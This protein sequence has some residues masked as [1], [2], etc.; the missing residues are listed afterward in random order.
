[1]MYVKVA[2]TIGSEFRFVC[3][4]ASESLFKRWLIMQQCCLY[5]STCDIDKE[6]F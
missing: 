3:L 2:S 4:C 1:M 5:T 6:Y